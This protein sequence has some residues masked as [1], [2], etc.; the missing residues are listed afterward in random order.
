MRA[1]ELTYNECGRFQ[2][3]INSH[4]LHL[5]LILCMCPGFYCNLKYASEKK[6]RYALFS[7][8][9]FIVVPGALA[10][11]V[12]FECAHTFHIQHV[13]NYKGMCD[14]V[15]NIH[16]SIYITHELF[17]VSQGC[18]NIRFSPHGYRGQGFHRI[19]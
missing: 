4:F 8:Y 17:Q 7:G 3:K 5:L 10:W 18:H 9:L 6:T 12:T 16:L 14:Y 13:R 19:K 2:E 11:Q 15:C 1:G